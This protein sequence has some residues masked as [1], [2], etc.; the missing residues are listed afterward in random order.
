LEDQLADTLARLGVARNE[1]PA[2][3]NQVTQRLSTDQDRDTLLLKE[4]L[5]GRG[6]YD[7]SIK[8]DDLFKLGGQYDRQRQDL[9]SATATQYRELSDAEAAARNSYQQGLVEAMMS[10]A[11]YY[12]ENP[13]WQVPSYGFTAGPPSYYDTL[14]EQGG[15]ANAPAQEQPQGPKA[16]GQP[17]RRWQPSWQPSW[18]PPKQRR[19]AGRRQTRR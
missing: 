12:A 6:V 15:G 13:N 8:S 14:W 2:M 18:Q 10:N 7:S 9:A 1:I 5:A 16:G 4:K 3:L 17:Q 19:Q 11:N